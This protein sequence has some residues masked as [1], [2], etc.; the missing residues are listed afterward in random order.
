M[1]ATE[2]APTVT[3]CDLGLH[4]TD[5]LDPGLVCWILGLS[6][7]PYPTTMLPSMPD[8][9]ARVRS[10]RPGTTPPATT[11]AAHVAGSTQGES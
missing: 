3:Q 6:P 4:P 2:P 5:L 8:S 9:N 11:C 10:R 7:R 1:P